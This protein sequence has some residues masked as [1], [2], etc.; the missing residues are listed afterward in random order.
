[1]F[2]DFLGDLIGGLIIGMAAAALINYLTSDRLKSEMRK[3]HADAVSMQVKNNLRSGNYNVISGVL[4]DDYK[5][6]LG[7]ESLKYEDA[8]SE[9]RSLRSGDWLSLT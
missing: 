6:S 4:F 3:K 9:I 8:P 5:D 1:M 7:E 2:G